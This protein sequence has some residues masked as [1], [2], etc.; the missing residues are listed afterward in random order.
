M[1]Y[2]NEKKTL[3]DLAKKSIQNGLTTQKPLVINT[4]EFPTKLQEFAAC[5]VTLQINHQLR[6]CIGSLTAFRPLVEDVTNNAFAAAFSDPRFPP[7]GKE[8][9]SEL[10]IH[11]SILSKP[12]PMQFGSEE[13]LLSQLQ[14]GIDGLILSDR[15]YRGT[16]LPSV[17]EQLPTP[18]LFL[19][20]LKL[21]AGL[22]EDYWSD[23]IKIERYEA[24]L[25]VE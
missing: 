21:K 24:E 9:F 12:E 23:T 15:G 14:P 3:L 16:F 2:Q 13:D 22:P 7:L 4:K 1:S 6:G 18:E 25:L 19:Q 10:E 5:F 8:E 11:I 20:H 17:W